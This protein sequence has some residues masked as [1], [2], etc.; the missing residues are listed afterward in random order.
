MDFVGFIVVF[1]MS[2]ALSKGCAC[3]VQ[4]GEAA[5]IQKN[6]AGR[7]AVREQ[8]CWKSNLFCRVIE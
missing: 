4:L 3:S 8:V 7:V 5:R 1:C 6:Q 2:M